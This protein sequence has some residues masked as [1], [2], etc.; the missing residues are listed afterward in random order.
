M[1][2]QQLGRD[3]EPEL[4]ASESGDRVVPADVVVAAAMAASVNGE[5]L[6]V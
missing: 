1:V 6:I 2:Q 4:V 3:A 5:L